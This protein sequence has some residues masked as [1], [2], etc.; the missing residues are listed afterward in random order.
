MNRVTTLRLLILEEMTN[1]PLINHLDLS[2]VI[3]HSRLTAI[4]LEVLLIVTINAKIIL[5]KDQSEK[6]SWN[7]NI[8][9]ASR[10]MKTT[11]IF[12]IIDHHLLIK[13]KIRDKCVVTNN[14]AKPTNLVVLYLI[15]HKVPRKL[16]CR[17]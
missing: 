12:Q 4:N 16:A 2:M 10:T 13:L 8:L 14:M 3:I 15:Y 17:I 6:T 11:F 5:N 7:M 1:G 9:P